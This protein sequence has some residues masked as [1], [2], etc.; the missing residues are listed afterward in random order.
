VADLQG[1]KAGEDV[2]YYWKDG[3]SFQGKLAG[4]ALRTGWVFRADGTRYPVQ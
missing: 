4:G 1:W 2:T 3:D